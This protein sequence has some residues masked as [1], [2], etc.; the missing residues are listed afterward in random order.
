MLRA[1]RRTSARNTRAA[2]I[3]D[4]GR[5][6]PVGGDRHR[7]AAAKGAR[8]ALRGVCG[9]DCG[10]AGRGRVCPRRP[11]ALRDSAAARRA[12]FPR[13]RRAT[14]PRSRTAGPA[15]RSRLRRERPA[16]EG[17]PR[18]REVGRSRG[19]PARAARDRRWRLARLSNHRDRLLA[20]LAAAGHGRAGAL[21]AA[22]A[23]SD[24]VGGPRHRVRAPRALGAAHAR[25]GRHRSDNPGNRLRPGDPRA[26]LPPPRGH[27]SPGRG[28]FRDGAPARRPRRGRN[29]GAHGDDS[30][31]GRARSRGTRRARAHRPVAARGERR[32]RR[33]AGRARRPL[34]RGIPQSS[35]RGAHRDD[36]GTPALLSGRRTTMAR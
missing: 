29:R 31:T 20:R 19:G 15:T 6:E 36:A 14:G 12:R 17:R 9:R 23:A 18:L 8:H 26:S 30:R 25:Q 13:T 3:D 7:R 1:G 32:A 11:D 16:D 22:G 35:E 4:D 2:E 33:M 28:R 27:R 10:G 24:A 21:P 5:K 34:R